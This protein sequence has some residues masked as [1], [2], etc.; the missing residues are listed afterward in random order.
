[1]RYLLLIAAFPLC[2]LAQGQHQFVRDS[3]G[4]GVFTVNTSNGNVGFCSAEPGTA[5]VK[6]KCSSGGINKPSPAG[7]YQFTAATPMNS[8]FLTNT[9]TGAVLYCK[10]SPLGGVQCVE[11]K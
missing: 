11:P 5:P 9:A 8:G 2:A 10:A 6:F 3:T 4:I 1:M 7:T